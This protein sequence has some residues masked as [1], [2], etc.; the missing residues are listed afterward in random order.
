M[1]R[2]AL[3]I[4]M[5]TVAVLSLSAMAFA[6]GPGMG[7]GMGAGMGRG[8]CGGPTQTLTPEQQQTLETLQSEFSTKTE[9]LRQEVYAKHME[10]EALLAAVKLDKAKIDAVTKQLVDLKGKMFQEMITFREKVREAGIQDFGAGRGSCGR[11]NRGHGQG[12]HDGSGPR[13]DSP[14]CPENNG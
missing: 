11:G 5:A 4:V 13:G 3:T 10:L 7:A 14:S 8:G 1:N 9:S 12:P 6:Y 2:K